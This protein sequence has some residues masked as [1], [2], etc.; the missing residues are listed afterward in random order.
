MHLAAQSAVRTSVEDPVLDASINILGLLNVLRCCVRHGVRKVVFAASGGTLYG[1][2]PRLPAWEPDRI[3]AVPASPYG[4]SKKVAEDY[5]RFFHRTY[6]VDF[7]ALGLANVYGP[8]QSPHGE[9]GVVAVFGSRM[10]EGSGPVIFGDGSQTRDFVHVRD[11]ARA[12]LLAASEAGSGMVANIGTGTETS[13]N[14]LFDRMARLTGFEGAPEYGPARE[15]EVARSALDASLAAA[16]LGWTP[17]VDLDEGL[18]D[19]VA[20][21]RTEAAARVAG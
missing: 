19:T 10:L 2:D 20:W 4:I 17:L 7:T 9:A 21:L 14:D 12:F 11:V 8:R 18:S 1:P 6:R 16:E 3:G 15:G 5:L 13:V